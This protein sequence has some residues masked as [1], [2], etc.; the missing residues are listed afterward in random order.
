MASSALQ[1]NE[2]RQ[3]F[4][5]LTRLLIAGATTIGRE[6]FD[7]IHPPA[8]L[9]TVLADPARQAIL[10]GSRMTRPQL[11]QVYPSPGTYGKSEDWDLTLLHKMLRNICGLTQPATGWD[12]LPPRLGHQQTSR[13]GEVEVLQ[14]LHIWTRRR[15]NGGKKWRV[16]EALEGYQ[17]GNYSSGRA[18]QLCQEEGM[19][20]R[21]WRFLDST[22]DQSWLAEHGR[23]K[24]VVP[25]GR[26][27]ERGIHKIEKGR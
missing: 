15:E 22:A 10:R 17:R 7:A 26:G 19:G 9:A 8:I 2:G 21:H 5:R 27:V 3:N 16:S 1:S 12:D 24:I 11:T 23:T 6:M 18:P 13:F 25:T 20:R 14:K 4:Q